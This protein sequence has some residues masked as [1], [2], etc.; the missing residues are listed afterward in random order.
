MEAAGMTTINDHDRF[1]PVHV[2]DVFYDEAAF[3]E[4]TYD[5]H[6]ERWRAECSCGWTGDWHDDAA[7]AESEGEDHREIAAGP[8]DGVDR[9]MGQLLD[10]QDDLARVVMWLAEHWA[11]DLPVPYSCGRGTIEDGARAHVSAYCVSP[12]DLERAAALLEVPLVDDPVPDAGGYQYRRATRHFGRATVEVYR[13]LTPSCDECGT[14]L[15]GEHCPICGDRRDARR[16][17]LGADG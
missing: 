4:A 12:V 1:A 11:A 5:R 10:L 17:T 3:A 7:V 14:T 15:A 6:A 9:L 16:V 8:G 2:V 13:T